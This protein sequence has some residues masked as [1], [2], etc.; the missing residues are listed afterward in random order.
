VTTYRKHASSR[1]VER[2]FIGAI[3]E[4]W[5]ARRLRFV[6]DPKNSNV[7]KKSYDGQRQVA[8]CNYTDVYY[9]ERL[10]S[11][12]EYMSATASDDEIEAFSL[13]RGDVIITKDSETADDIGIPAYVAEDLPGVVCGYHL[14]MLR[15]RGV[16]GE[17]LFRV[18]QAHATKA[19]F[20]VEV[21]G[22]TRYG[23]SQDT[24]RDVIVPVPPLEVQRAI[25]QWIN[26]E[27]AR[28]DAL[29]EKKTRFIELLHEKRQALVTEAVT[30]GTNA[31]A[32]RRSTGIDWLGSVP[33][34]WAVR[35]LKYIARVQTGV[36]K[37][38]DYGGI[39]TVEVPY[40]RV[41]NVQDG[42]LDLDDVATI[43]IAASDLERYRLRRGDVLM[44]EGGDF[45]KLGRGHVWQ[46]EIDP[47][48][49]QNHVFAVRPTGVTSEWLNAFTG[50][51]PAQ[52]YFMG[53]SKQ[54]TNLA[55]ISSSN[56]MELPVPIP[57]H[58]EQMSILRDLAVKLER[59]VALSSATERSLALLRERRAALITAAVTG[60]IDVRTEQDTESLEPA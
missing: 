55:S 39:E 24:I 43:E 58:A 60:Q 49:H 37:G 27:T 42:F 41:A 48:I 50:S 8:L 1:P 14:C 19:F 11:A 30:L 21:S 26:A 51:S 47:C 45:D 57:P 44:N 7:D 23:L 13:S 4:N 52:F 17:F 16:L 36:A 40:L 56:L 3:P 25:C 54:S 10:S 28:I 32:P 59:T 53:R 46:G 35:P 31:K 29:I 34:H 9:N 12:L 15:P 5:T 20:F 2:G 22:V 6:A 38:K 33:A 18:I